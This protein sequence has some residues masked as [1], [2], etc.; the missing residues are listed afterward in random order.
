MGKTSLGS[1]AMEW[2]IALKIAMKKRTVF[3]LICLL[4]HDNKQGLGCCGF[5]QR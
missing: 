1:W 3:M 2:L 5:L 4:I